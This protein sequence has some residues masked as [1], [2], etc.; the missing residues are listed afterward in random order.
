MSR[1]LFVAQMLAQAHR[2]RRLLDS[3]EVPSAAELARRLGF[4]RARIS[5][6]L[7]LTLLA[8]DIQEWLLFATNDRGRDIITERDLRAVAQLRLWEDQRTEFHRALAWK[9]LT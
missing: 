8:P 1:P 2:M 6:L 5:Q 7:D 9:A 4:T 3:G